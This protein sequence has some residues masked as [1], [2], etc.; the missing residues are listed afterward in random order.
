M[1]PGFALTSRIDVQECG[2][3]QRKDS[4]QTMWLSTIVMEV[5]QSWFGEALAFVERTELHVINNGTLTAQRY[6]DE[7]LAVHVRSYAGAIGPFFLLMDDNATAH[8]ARI[9]QEYLQRETIE[10]MDWPARSPDLNPIE[11][12]W[13]MLQTAKCGPCCS[14]T[15][16]PGAQNSSC[17]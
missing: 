9:V 4:I 12:V 6:R 1:N 8:R 13:D 15:K 16:S 10:R 17:G 14:T 7:I 3:Y 2:D 11:H 5:A